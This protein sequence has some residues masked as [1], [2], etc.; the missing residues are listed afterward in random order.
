AL[1]T[2]DAL[3]PVFN[4]LAQTIER[5][6]LPIQDLLDLLSAFEQDVTVNRYAD[7]LALLDYCNRSA[8]PVGRLMLH[9]YDARNNDNTRDPDA[10]CPGPQLTNIWQD[11][12][13]D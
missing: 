7:R 9:L 8:N 4:P 2:D 3:A 1:P 6:K 11:V 5:H 10:T 12:S 13:I